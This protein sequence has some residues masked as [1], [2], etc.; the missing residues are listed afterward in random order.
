MALIDK[1][2]YL[3]VAGVQ[4]VMLKLDASTGAVVEILPVVSQYSMMRAG[5]YICA[6]TTTGSID[7]LDPNTLQLI[8][9]WQ[10]HT[11]SVSDMALS[12]SSLVSCGRAVRPIG[13]AMLENFAKVYDLKNLEQLAPIPFPTGAA[14]VQIHP[15]LST[16]CVLGAPVGQL[17]V[18]DLV[19]PETSNMVFFANSLT[20]FVMSGS[21]N[22]WAVVEDHNIIHLWGS[23][24]KALNFNDDV[25]LP[26]YADEI[27]PVRYLGVDEDM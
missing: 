1:G 17:Q 19:N 18:I 26:E 20:H 15:K 24:S 23:P 12:S 2:N 16:T 5:R 11:A 8:K 14:Y 9:A 4:S 27:E 25:Q 7:F 22:L 13:P 6:A 21:G 10:A 3:L